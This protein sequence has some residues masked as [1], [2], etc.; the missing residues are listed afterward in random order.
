M[1]TKA[2]HPLYSGVTGRLLP[3]AIFLIAALLVYFVLARQFPMSG[4][5]YSYL[6]QA[7][8][9]ASGKM[10]AEDLFTTET[11]RFTTA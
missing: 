2:D 4:D 9:F 8:L 10:Y 6:Y 7:R 5:D 1:T 11:F 3:S